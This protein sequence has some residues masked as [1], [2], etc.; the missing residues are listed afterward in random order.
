MASENVMRKKLDRYQS[1]EGELI[2][3]G[4][5]LG[6]VVARFN[7]FIGE[8]LLAGALDAVERSGGKTL[9]CDVIWVPGSLEIPVAAKEMGNS[10]L[11]DSIVCLGAII[12]GETAHYDHVAHETSVGIGQA[13]LDTGVPTIFGVLTCDTL[14]QAINRAGA[15]SGNKGFEAGVAAIEMANLLKEIRTEPSAGK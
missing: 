14:E 15:K 6:F 1:I 11:Y 13:G 3:T 8:R 4:L 5:R 10:G 9:A 2:A 12:R 7:R